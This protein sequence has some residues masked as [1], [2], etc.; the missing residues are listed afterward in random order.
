MRA[1]RLANVGGLRRI[2]ASS[3]CHMAYSLHSL[4]VACFDLTLALIVLA[5]TCLRDLWKTRSWARQSY[6]LV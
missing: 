3:M 2:L 4:V 1:R 5:L 6:L